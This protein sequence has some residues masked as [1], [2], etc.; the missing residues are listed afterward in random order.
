MYTFILDYDEGTYISQIKS[1]ALER[2]VLKWAEA[3]DIEAIDGCLNKH[4]MQIISEIKSEFEK[5][6]P[7]KEMNNVWFMS[8]I[9]KN[10]LPV[11]LSFQ[12]HKI[13]W[14]NKNKG[15]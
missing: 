15:I 14:P 11:R 6:I 10:K 13:I 7:I 8:F 5:P 9:I 12:F 2:A 4:K 3:L 1:R